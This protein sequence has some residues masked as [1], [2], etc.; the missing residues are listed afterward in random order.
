MTDNPAL[1]QAYLLRLWPVEAN[2]RTYWRAFIQDVTSGDRRG[3][4]TLEALFAYL[5]EETRRLEERPDAW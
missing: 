5:R 2:G 1:Y 3:F 4:E